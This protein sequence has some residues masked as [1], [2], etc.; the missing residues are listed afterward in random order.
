M[1]RAD[2]ALTDPMPEDLRTS[3]HVLLPVSPIFKHERRWAR[4]SRQ[5]MAVYRKG[6]RGDAVV[7]AVAA[8]RSGRHKDMTRERRVEAVMEAKAFGLVHTVNF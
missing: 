8:Q 7:R 2:R 1:V 6:V 5:Y 4:I 3:E